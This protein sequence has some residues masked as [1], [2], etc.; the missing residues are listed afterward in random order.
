M[1]DFTNLERNA[2]QT[3][4]EIPSHACYID[5]PITD[6]SGKWFATCL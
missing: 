6:F 1:S 4:N 5:Y 3:H 2:N